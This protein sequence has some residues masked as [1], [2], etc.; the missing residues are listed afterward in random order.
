MIANGYKYPGRSLVAFALI[1]AATFI[2]AGCKSER[3][4]Q[5]AAANTPNNNLSPSPTSSVVSV[6]SAA[7]K[8]ATTTPTLVANSSSPSPRRGAVSNENEPAVSPATTPL[9]QKSQRDLSTALPYPG[10][11]SGVGPG[12]G[13][14]G[15]DNP[16]RIRRDP[17]TIDYNQI[18]SGRDVD[19][20]AHVLE[21]PDPGYTAAARRDEIT[22]TVVLGFVLAANGQVTDIKVMNGL[23]DGL[24]E[25]AVAAAKR[26]KFKPAMINGRAVSTYMQLEYNFNLY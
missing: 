8:P 26:V 12:N 15:I 10:T 14:G 1:L 13:G 11:G 4:E 20:R 3:S 25:L 19:Q 16:N 17:S 24:T 18:F 22:G 2:S 9:P 5:P 23:P 7:P 6:E 21:K